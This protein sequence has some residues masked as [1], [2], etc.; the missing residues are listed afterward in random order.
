MFW[1]TII[2]NSIKTNQ[3]VGL[4][5]IYELKTQKKYPH[6]R[7]ITCIQKI[8]SVPPNLFQWYTFNFSKSRVRDNFL[9][10]SHMV[11]FDVREMQ[12]G[13]AARHGLLKLSGTST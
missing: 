11:C 5:A 8:D 9:A 13:K 2:R 6:A 12:V 3:L 7:K 1:N 10:V 4:R